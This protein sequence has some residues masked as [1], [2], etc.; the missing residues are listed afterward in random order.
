MRGTGCLL[1]GNLICS[2]TV[3]SV[4][5]QIVLYSLPSTCKNLGSSTSACFLDWK[6]TFDNRQL[7]HTVISRQEANEAANAFASK[8]SRSMHRCCHP[9][10][11]T[12]GNLQL[13]RSAVMKLALFVSVIV[14]I[15]PVSSAQCRTIVRNRSMP[16]MLRTRY[17]R[18]QSVKNVI[19]ESAPINSITGGG[20]VKLSSLSSMMLISG[21]LTMQS[22]TSKSMT[23]SSGGNTGVISSV[24]MIC[25]WRCGSMKC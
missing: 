21:P 6:Y 4:P 24:V 20:F 13:C 3:T 14:F 17:C 5:T 22:S 19:L 16:L 11:S 10:S 7:P 1:G 8:S 12:S 15:S 9:S 2:I 23:E 18:E 25:F